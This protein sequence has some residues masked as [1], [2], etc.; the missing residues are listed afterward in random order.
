MDTALTQ[1]FLFILDRNW[2]KANCT[3]NRVC[4]SCD[5]VVLALS[6]RRGFER[7]FDTTCLVVV[8]AEFPNALAEVQVFFVAALCVQAWQK[9]ML[10]NAG[11]PKLY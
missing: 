11:Q 1:K 6:I 9:E 4:T 2:A 5:T 8:A 7:S 3:G 10:C